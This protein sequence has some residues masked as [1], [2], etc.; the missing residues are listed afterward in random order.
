M[1]SSTVTLKRRGHQV[2]RYSELTP[3]FLSWL[4]DVTQAQKHAQLVQEAR[5]AY[6]FRRR[7][8]RAKIEARALTKKQAKRKAKIITIIKTA[9]LPTLALM[10]YT[11]YRLIGFVHDLRN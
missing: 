3:R 9:F 5:D 10:G 4:R 2:I 11:L 7:M 8:Q 1:R 6:S